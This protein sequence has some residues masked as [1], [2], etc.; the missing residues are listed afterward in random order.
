MSAPPLECIVCDPKILL[1]FIIVLMEKVEHFS[2]TTCNLKPNEKKC[3]AFRIFQ[4]HLLVD[5]QGLERPPSEILV[6]LPI[7]VH[8]TELDGTRGLKSA[9]LTW[10]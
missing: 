2:C 4:F 1:L 3:L 7:I 5:R 6:P 10:E 9:I 8:C